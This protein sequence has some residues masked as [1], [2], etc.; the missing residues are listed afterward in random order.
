[1]SC[2]HADIPTIIDA[3]HALFPTS[4]ALVIVVG[5]TIDHRFF[6]SLVVVT[7]H[8]DIPDASELQHPSLGDA[9]AEVSD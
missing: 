6:L 9:D 2:V 3:Y 1:M 8:L 4:H 7:A 5:V